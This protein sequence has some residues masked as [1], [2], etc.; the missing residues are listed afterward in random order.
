M[1]CEIISLSGR[2]KAQ[3]LC[4]V[5]QEEAG[6]ISKRTGLDRKQGQSERLAPLSYG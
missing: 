4:A 6:L 3:G 1:E 2:R 5:R